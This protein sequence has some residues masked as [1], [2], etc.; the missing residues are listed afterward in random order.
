MIPVPEPTGDVNGDGFYDGVD[1]LELQRGFG[2]LYSKADFADWRRNFG[3]APALA[4]LSTVPEP[5]G[6]MLAMAATLG[7]I[8]GRWR[9]W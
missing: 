7:T 2:D 5:T 6:W 3:N 4:A 8:A 1:F 9:R